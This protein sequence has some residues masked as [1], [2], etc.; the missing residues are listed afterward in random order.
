LIT[1]STLNTSPAWSTI[2]SQL[3]LEATL[4]ARATNATTG[5]A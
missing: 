2:F 1:V 4:D 3:Q 5:E